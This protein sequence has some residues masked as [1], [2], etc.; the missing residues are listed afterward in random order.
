MT[1]VVGDGRGT[2]KHM[3]YKLHYLA[4]SKKINHLYFFEIGFI[5]QSLLALFFHIEYNIQTWIKDICKSFLEFQ[6]FIT[7]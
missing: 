6:T 3:L 1:K 2:T 4:K 5:F 7:L